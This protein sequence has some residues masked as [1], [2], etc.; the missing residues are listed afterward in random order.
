MRISVSRLSVTGV[1]PGGILMAI[2][3]WVFLVEVR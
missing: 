2:F 3:Y 1:T